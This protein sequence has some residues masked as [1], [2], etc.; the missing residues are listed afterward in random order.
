MSQQITTLTFFKY[1]S[2]QQKLW[3]FGMMQFAHAPLKKVKGLEFYKLL[4]SGKK[5]FDPLP[6]WGVYG[7]LQVW[8]N[9]ASA[10]DFFA[11]AKLY[12]RYV[13]H[14]AQQLTFYL[15][16][17]KAHGQWSKQNPFE[18][19]DLLD[20]NNEMIAVITRATIKLRMLKKFWDYVP[21]SQ[22]DLVDNPSLLFTAGVGERPVTQMA[23]FSL[24][25]DA[26]ALKKFAYRSQ[27]H[28]HAVQQTQALQWYKEEMFTR[29]QP[30]KIT[31]QWSG[32]EIPPSLISNEQ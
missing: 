9:E 30:F 19:S 16:S 8:D 22:K 15:K 13:N 29:F 7:L 32:F 2:L 6:D 27:N 28:R 26:R 24:W 18:S 25:E 11:E 1:P 10:K 4:G 14:S 20:E 3:A 31:G 23:T 5:N 21:I 17:I 12:K